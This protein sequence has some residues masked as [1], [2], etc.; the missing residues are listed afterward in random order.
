[1]SAGTKIMGVEFAPL[2]IPLKRRLQT[3]AVWQWTLSFLF[4]GLLCLGFMIY[5]C[6]T[7]WYPI[8]LLY[9]V[10]GVVCLRLPHARTWRQGL[11]LGTAL[12]HLETL[13][14][15]LSCEACENSVTEPEEELYIGSPSPWHNGS[16]SVRKLCDRCDRFRYSVPWNPPDTA[17]HRLPV[18]VPTPQGI[19]HG[20]R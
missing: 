13:Q 9:A 16:W 5:L 1:M 18:F 17:D 20:I 19:L 10:Y 14:R 6:F 2:R 7:P 12:G 4:L 8:P 15:L 3:F 11:G